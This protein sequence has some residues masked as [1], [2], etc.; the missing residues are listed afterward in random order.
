MTC[1]SR[2]RNKRG[3]FVY[4]SVVAARSINISIVTP[5]IKYGM[6]YHKTYERAVNGGD[7]IILLKEINKF[8]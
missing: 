6:I 7:F 4:I 1:P 5:I 2:G 3:E 8:C